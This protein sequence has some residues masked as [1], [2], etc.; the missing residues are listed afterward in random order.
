MGYNQVRDIIGARG[1]SI[2]RC[3]DDDEAV[4]TVVRYSK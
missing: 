3:I 2:L 4:S 1:A